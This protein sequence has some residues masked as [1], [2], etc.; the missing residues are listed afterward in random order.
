MTPEETHALIDHLDE[1]RTGKPSG[2]ME[3]FI[4]G[5]A[6]AAQ[7]WYCMNIALDAIRNAGLHEQVAAIRESLQTE[8]ENKE[9]A[10]TDQYIAAPVNKSTA[11]QQPSTRP[12]I[13][14]NI[15]GYGLRA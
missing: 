11:A 10:V 9:P 3:K 2:E 1:N 5:N 13:V 7:E 15:G 4:A 14:R 6:D 12:A 8:Q